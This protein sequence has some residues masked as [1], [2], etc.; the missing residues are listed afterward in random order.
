MNQAGRNRGPHRIGNDMGDQRRID[1]RRHAARHLADGERPET[2]ATWMKLPVAEVHE[3]M[4][5][6]EFD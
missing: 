4:M 6:L 2:V 5:S 1:R 3:L